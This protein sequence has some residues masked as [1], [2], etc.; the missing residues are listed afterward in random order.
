[1]RGI[2][3]NNPYITESGKTVKVIGTGQRN[4]GSGPDFTGCILEI[5]GE[6]WTGDVEIHVHERDW[7]HHGH[8]GDSSFDNVKLHFCVNT[9]SRPVAP[10]Q[11]QYTIQVDPERQTERSRI[12]FPADLNW[13]EYPCPAGEKLAEN[14]EQV[15][16]VL[17]GIEHLGMQRIRR[18]SLEVDRLIRREE[19]RLNTFAHLLCYS[20]GLHANKEPACNLITTINL[21]KLK[22][23]LQHYNNSAK[24]QRYGESILLRAGGL[25]TEQEATV[26]AKQ[27]YEWRVYREKLDRISGRVPSRIRSETWETSDVRP[28]NTPHRRL[29]GFVALFRR[30][31][32]GFSATQVEK[33]LLSRVSSL[34]SQGENVEEVMSDL[35]NTL[36]VHADDVTSYWVTHALPAKHLSKPSALIGPHRAGVLWLNGLLPHLLAVSR[37]RGRKRI[38]E[39]LWSLA[40][41]AEIPAGDHRTKFIKNHLFGKGADQIPETSLT[42]QGMHE[43]YRENCRFGSSG[44]SRCPALKQFHRKS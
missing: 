29:A 12:G 38:T 27:E 30:L 8:S 5:D 42:D 1:M 25:I 28:I 41:H 44:C 22:R 10:D 14:P 26:P 40:R 9:M 21:T 2:P 13:N 37:H 24:A 43:L 33:F 16:R 17:K 11:I 39:K 36:S 34:K 4:T 15:G 19:D 6:I 20:L 18:R 31:F 7:L 23:E 3:K 32:V 35:L